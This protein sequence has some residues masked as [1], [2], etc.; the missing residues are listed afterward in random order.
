MTDRTSSQTS[1]KGGFTVDALPGIDSFKT[2]ADDNLARFNATL[3]EVAR[4][5]REH[6]EATSRAIAEG[7]RLMQENLKHT[8]LL[9][10]E[11]LKMTVEATRRAVDLSTHG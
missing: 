8:A 7:A 11:W 6:V 2:M 1:N 9:S 4:L 5:Q 3:D 10:G